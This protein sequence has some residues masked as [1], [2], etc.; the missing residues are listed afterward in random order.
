MPLYVFYALQIIFILGKQIVYFHLY[1]IQ[2]YILCTV[3]KIKLTPEERLHTD[4]KY[5]HIELK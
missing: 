1:S 4:D 3:T 2:V 5:L